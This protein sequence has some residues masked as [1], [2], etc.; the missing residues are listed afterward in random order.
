MSKTKAKP[1]KGVG[2]GTGSKGWNRW[3]SSARKKKIAKPYK[4][5]SKGT[6]K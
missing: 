4:N 1:K 3:Q 5:K 2:Q 6:N